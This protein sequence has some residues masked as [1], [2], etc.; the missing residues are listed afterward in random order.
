MLLRQLSEYYKNCLCIQNKCHAAPHHQ[1]L[2][3]SLWKPEKP[4][5]QFKQ[6]SGFL[7]L[8]PHINCTIITSGQI[9]ADPSLLFRIAVAALEIQSIIINANFSAWQFANSSSMGNFPLIC[10]ISQDS[11]LLPIF[12]MEALSDAWKYDFCCPAS[13]QLQELWLKSCLYET[14]M[15]TFFIFSSIL[16]KKLI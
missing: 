3:L 8:S 14:C 16:N 4:G 5:S 7:L 1:N 6:Q 13:F 11:S 9:A 2:S 15:A 12:I 10:K